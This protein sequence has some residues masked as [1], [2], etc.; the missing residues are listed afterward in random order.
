MNMSIPTQL[1]GIYPFG[2]SVYKHV[3][4]EL[5]SKLEHHS[6]PAI[7]LGLAPLVKGVV[8][9]SLK[10][11]KRSVTAVFVAHE[12][13]F[14]LKLNLIQ[15]APYE[16]QKA[17]SKLGAVSS[18]SV[19]WPAGVSNL[20]VDAF[21]DARMNMPVANH[22][23]VEVPIAPPRRSPR[24]HMPAVFPSVG[25]V[26]DAPS[27]SSPAA[28]V[29][30]TS[31]IFGW[32]GQDLDED[33]LPSKHVLLATP[34]KEGPL[35]RHEFLEL[36]P[37]S[38]KAAKRGPHYKYWFA[39]E[40][41]EVAAHI[42]NETFG[43]KLSSPP[44]GFHAISM[45]FVY[46]NKNIADTSLTPAELCPTMFKV[47]AVVKGY[48]MVEGVDFSDTFAPTPS[49]TSIRIMMM[50]RRLFSLMTTPS[51]ADGSLRAC[52]ASSKGQGCST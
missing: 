46:R 36:T 7:Y 4:K 39:G 43:A 22:D 11:S 48:T 19:F 23:E 5:R 29:L 6:E 20:P 21:K 12:A 13:H 30:L 40:L 34:V 15:P 41:R 35:T 42:R 26:V 27:T 38:H 9:L 8:V 51:L 50:Y 24:E 16:F 44:N 47:R 17:H 10:D 28:S 1:N 25:K 49:P 52:Q 32:L 33:P 3:P 2:C 18:P 31:P 45:G 37:I 14:P